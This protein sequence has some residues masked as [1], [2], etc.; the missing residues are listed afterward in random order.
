MEVGASAARLDGRH[1]VHL[2]AS[3][4]LSQLSHRQD[5]STFSN[6]VRHSLLSKMSLLSSL[7]EHIRKGFKT[8]AQI[9]VQIEKYQV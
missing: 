7:L 5:T 2:N 9:V 4:F 6:H 8:D 1:P 3:L